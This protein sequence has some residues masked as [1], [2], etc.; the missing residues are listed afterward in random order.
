MTKVY[1]PIG[2]AKRKLEEEVQD[3]ID[4]LTLTDEERMLKKLFPFLFP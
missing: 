3:M 4:M 1:D 2:H